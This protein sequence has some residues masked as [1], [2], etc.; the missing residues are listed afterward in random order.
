VLGWKD[1]KVIDKAERERGTRV[2][3]EREKFGS[4]GEMLKCLDA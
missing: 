1:W 3:K 2:G 4:V